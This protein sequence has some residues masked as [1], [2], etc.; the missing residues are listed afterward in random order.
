MAQ[1][2]ASSGP[3][4]RARWLRTVGIVAAVLVG[5]AVLLYAALAAALRSQRV[6]DLIRAQITSATGRDAAF[7]GGLQLD[8]WPR[9]AVVA[10]GLWLANAPGASSPR[11]LTARRVAFAVAL[12]PLLDRRIVVESVEV[13]GAELRIEALADGRS[14]WQL[15][16]RPA[17]GAASTGAGQAPAQLR[18][19]QVRL[20]DARLVFVEAATKPPQTLDVRSAS[21]VVVNERSEVDAEFAMRGQSWRLHAVTGRIEALATRRE[22]WP[23]D[24]DLTTAGL[25]VGLRGEIPPARG[26]GGAGWSIRVDA[27]LTDAGALA[28]W[29]GAG[30]RPP[31]PLSVRATVASRADAWRIDPIEGSVAGDAFTGRLTLALRQRPEVNGALRFNA[32]D[33]KHWLPAL[34]PSPHAPPAGDSALLPSTGW[35]VVGALELAVGRLSVPQWPAIQAMAVRVKLTP[36]RLDVPAVS[37]EVAGGRVK[38]SGHVE[39]RGRAEPEVSLRLDASDLSLKT[40]GDAAGQA[41]AVR[42]GQ[43]RVTASLSGRGDDAASLMSHLTGDVALSLTDVAFGEKGGFWRTD[44]IRGVLKRL[45]PADSTRADVL[46]CVVVRLPLR[47]GKATI[48]RTIALETSELD[49]VAVGRVDL[50]AQTLDLAFRPALKKGVGLNPANLAQFVKLH[51]PI[52][53]PE[54]TIDM[55]GS[56]RGAVSIGAAV[57]TGGLTLIGERALRRAVDPNP[58]QAAL[59]RP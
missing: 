7:D 30:A 58:C 34:A 57:A 38:A 3:V 12:P 4:S 19:E 50:Q 11:M 45:M 32:L 59:K 10:N 8:L 21:L 51:G 52:A 46:R 54:Y 20:A 28:P 14:N 18:V 44:L 9:I 17:S 2:P 41:G 33:L 5:I 26:A 15:D 29:A 24:A 47:D 55:A 36:E 27:Q 37:L 1:F 23:F 39:L 25:R 43:G 42:S 13:E 16:G 6:A 56:V 35:P 48:D 49:V 40:L 31:V 53:A 22:P